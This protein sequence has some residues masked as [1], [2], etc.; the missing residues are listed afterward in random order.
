MNPRKG[1][2]IVVFVLLIMGLFFFMPMS[3]LI[4]ADAPYIFGIMTSVI[5]LFMIIGILVFIRFAV[6]N[7]KRIQDQYSILGDQQCISC[8][9][10]SSA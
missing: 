5:V 3:F 8:G 7:A 10:C 6:K 1:R 2:K 9:N 4:F